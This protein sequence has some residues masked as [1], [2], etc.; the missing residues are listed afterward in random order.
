MAQS[1]AVTFLRVLYI[2]TCQRAN[3][4]TAWRLQITNDS[5]NCCG[6]Q[7]QMMDGDGSLR[8]KFH[9]AT[10]KDNIGRH[11]YAN[12]TRPTCL[13]RRSFSLVNKSR[14]YT[15]THTHT[16]PSFLRGPHFW[17][18][19]TCPSKQRAK[20]NSSPKIW[21]NPSRPSY[22]ISSHQQRLRKETRWVCCLLFWVSQYQRQLY[23]FFLH[24]F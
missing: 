12:Q 7:Q 3:I 10:L 13:E 9:Q 8:P 15:H 24:W 17:V 14:L 19:S 2:D 5:I 6:C 23:W 20:G 18:A 22:V 11:S 4:L 21:D 16:Y 1:C